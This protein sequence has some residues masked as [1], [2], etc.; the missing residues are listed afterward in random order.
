MR[1]GAVDQRAHRVAAVR[2]ARIA[3]LQPPV[4]IPG[5]HPRVPGRLPDLPCQQARKPHR[6][7]RGEQKPRRP[8]PAIR[9]IQR[10][11]PGQD[12]Q[13]QGG[14]GGDPRRQFVD[15][16]EAVRRNK[17]DEDPAHRS[18][19]R[20][21]QVIGGEV[22]GRRLHPGQLAMAHHAA[23]EEPTGKKGDQNRKPFGLMPLGEQKGHPPERQGKERQ[24]RASAVPAL[25]GEA[26]DEAQQV[27]G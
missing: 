13:G 11:E 25:P 20:N 24:V 22:A 23:D 8:P 9:R 27:K 26:Q 1:D 2:G 3:H 17:A 12:D 16:T 5:Q 21:H 4:E 14:A 6:T 15:S 19:Q 18:P 7:D 10:P